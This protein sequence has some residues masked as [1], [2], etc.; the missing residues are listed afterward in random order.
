MMVDLPNLKDDEKATFERLVN[1]ALQRQRCPMNDSGTGKR[2]KN[3]PR[4]ARAGFIRIEIFAH[5]FR[6]VTILVGPHTGLSTLSP[7]GNQ[8]P[9]KI[10]DIYGTTNNGKPVA[11]ARG[12]QQPWA[13]KLSSR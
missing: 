13:P 4:L 2:F 7:R 3:L 11:D 10:I 5:N 9:W 12:R 6:R 1:T 8:K